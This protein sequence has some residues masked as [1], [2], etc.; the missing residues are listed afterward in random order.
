[1]TPRVVESVLV[2]VCVL[3][4]ASL[5]RALEIRVRAGE[6]ECVTERVREARTMVSGSWFVT[7][8]SNANAP[9][10]R[11]PGYGDHYLSLIHI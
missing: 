1:M 4:V 2:V 9:S 10:E 7:R 3:G 6:T 8:A 5:A 11:G